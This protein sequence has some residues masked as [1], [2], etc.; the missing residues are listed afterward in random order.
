[1]I[2]DAP[3]MAAGGEA[4][5]MAQ[6][7][8]FLEVAKAKAAGGIT[9]SEFGELLVALLRLSVETLDAVLGMSGAEK[10][11]LVLEAVAALF[12]QLAD[13]AVP[14]VVWPVWILARPAIRALVLAIAS[15][16]IEIVLPLTRA[17]E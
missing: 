5:L 11:S 9:W 14:V 10:K 8:A 15:G 7:A 13:K 3:V 4:T 12:D 2:S 16:A 1:M 17:A 6:V